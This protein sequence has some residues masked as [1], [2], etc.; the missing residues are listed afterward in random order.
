MC[1][2]KAGMSPYGYKQTS[3]GPKLKS[4]LPPRPDILVA[5]TLENYAVL[6][7]M[8]GRIQD[9]MRLKQRAAEIRAQSN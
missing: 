1:L 8:T 9:A 5:D 7:M 2:K 6:L 4:A 3:S